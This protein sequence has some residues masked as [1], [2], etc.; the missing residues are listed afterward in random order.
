[1]SSASC[2]PTQLAQLPQA[3]I[4]HLCA[5]QTVPPPPRGRHRRHRRLAASPRRRRSAHLSIITR[6]KAKAKAVITRGQTRGTRIAS[7]GRRRSDCTSAPPR[8][9]LFGRRRSG[10]GRRTTLRRIISRAALFFLRLRLY[11]PQSLG[12]WPAPALTCSAKR[13]RC[14]RCLLLS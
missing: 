13:S 8:L 2:G 1:M 14:G 7:A 3:P 12:A 9:V 6:R 5:M 4:P 10:R 11:R